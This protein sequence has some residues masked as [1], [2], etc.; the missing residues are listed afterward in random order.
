MDKAYRIYARIGSCLYLS[1]DGKRLCHVAISDCPP[2]LFAVLSGDHLTLVDSRLA[3]AKRAACALG[4]ESN[5]GSEDQPLRA[6]PTSDGTVIISAGQSTLRIVGDGTCILSDAPVDSACEFILA[7]QSEMLKLSNTIIV[8]DDE[9]SFDVFEPTLE[10]PGVAHYAE[11]LVEDGKLGRALEVILHVTNAN[12]LKPRFKGRS[13]FIRDLDRVLEK[14]SD[15]LWTGLRG[16]SDSGHNLIIATEIYVAGGHTRILEDLADLSPNNIVLLTDCFR[17]IEQGR[18]D[19]SYFKK[20]LP[21]TK[22]VRLGSTV[23]LDKVKHLIRFVNE[24]R[25]KGVYFLSHH[26]DPIPFAALASASVRQSRYLVHHADHNPSLGVTYSSFEHYDCTRHLS[27]VCSCVLGRDTK[28]L[29]LSV[30]D[31]GLSESTRF[32]TVRIST[33]T[34]GNIVKF[35]KSGPFAYPEIV[36][37]LLGCVEGKHYHIGYLPPDWISAVEDSLDRSGIDRDRF[38]CL[39]VVPSLWQTL[40]TIDAQVYIASA[41]TPGTRAAI[42]AQGAGLPALFLR[43]ASVEPLLRMQ[44]MYA[45][46]DLGWSVIGDISN[47]LSKLRSNY[48]AYAQKAREHYEINYSRRAFEDAIK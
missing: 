23:L 14:I 30:A 8:A 42:E 2:N 10:F 26:Q 29:P 4:D 35:S 39:G 33:V 11:R 31:E 13:L 28:Y 36:A 27:A 24:I 37:A 38:C 22:I 16:A 20:R 9:H 6:T 5:W 17:N 34:A 44:E 3:Q 21:N 1:E 43:S 25:P 45:N 15:V 48:T 41:P 46:Q 7:P 40:K 18:I 32:E 19:L 12:C 47:R